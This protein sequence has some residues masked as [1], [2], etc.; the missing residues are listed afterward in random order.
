MASVLPQ[1]YTG[2]ADDTPQKA[3]PRYAGVSDRDAEVLRSRAIPPH[4]AA[5]RG[6]R[7]ITADEACD[8]GLRACAGLLIPSWNTQGEIER[9]QLRPHD[10]PIDPDNGRPR[11]YL[12]AAGSHQTIDA[13]PTP[14]NLEALRNVKA[15]VIITEAPLKADAIAAALEAGGIDGVAVIAVAG[16]YGWRSDGMPLS[17]FGDLPWRHK[18]REA[19]RHRRRVYLAFDSDAATNPNVGRARWELAQYLRRRGAR[20]KFIDVPPADDGGKQGIDDA[21]AA[22]I[23]L[24]EMVSAAYPAPDIM[25]EIGRQLSAD[26]YDD[27][28]VP[29][30]ERLRARIAY[31]ERENAALVRTSKNP[32][33]TG[34][35]RALVLNAGTLALSKASRGQADDRGRVT[36]TPAE[37]S[38]DFRPK[39]EAGAPRMKHN[40]DGTPFLM[41]RSSVK[42]LAA[43]AKAAG[44]IDFEMH[45]TRKDRGN[46]RPYWDD[47]LIVTVPGSLA[48]FIAPAA[49]YAP[50]EP[51][52]RKDYRY[53]DPC[54]H[55][56][57]VH[58]RTVLRQTICGTEDDPGCGAVIR[59]TTV[60]LPVPAADRPAD[61]LTPEQRERLEAATAAD[62]EAAG[63]VTKNVPIDDDPVNT[64]SPA[65][66]FSSVTKNVPVPGDLYRDRSRG[67]FA[68]VNTAPERTRKPDG[69]CREDG[70]TNL[71]A[72][73]H[74]YC[75]DHEHPTA[76]TAAPPASPCVDCGELTTNRYRCDACIDRA[77][78]GVH[79][80]GI[81]HAAVNPVAVHDWLRAQ[82]ASGPRPASEIVASAEAAG[83]DPSFLEDV[84]TH[85]GIDRIAIDG[86]VMWRASEA[87]RR[88]EV[89]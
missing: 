35:M 83:I 41:T 6:H 5:A 14:A 22:G 74:L 11:K 40:P 38:G 28:R 64:P 25:P 57:E 16:V 67:V 87:R 42:K 81:D 43:E 2:S 77:R 53:Q 82:L 20:V 19:I 15:P 33:L 89:A 8:L 59:E 58:A 7:T 29:E 61:E 49:A 52:T 54:P 37:I 23:D 73:G 9:Y 44:L 1:Y 13:P 17:D 85:H 56:G 75:A 46:G 70:C 31:L 71:P 21:L 30:V 45:K 78:G 27:E 60:T 26:H 72:A 63:T 51:K 88:R 4:I 79:P 18:E 12:W 50:S 68:Y 80:A 69:L 47:D 39:P 34:A 32:N 65:R 36:L 55:C 62:A 84:R 86:V 48:D 24:R 10:P 3:R 66:T 76:A